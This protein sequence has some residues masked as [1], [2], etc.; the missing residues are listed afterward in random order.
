VVECWLR[1]RCGGDGKNRMTTQ[2]AKNNN[3][4]NNNNQIHLTTLI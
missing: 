3:K 2:N 1:V 4:N